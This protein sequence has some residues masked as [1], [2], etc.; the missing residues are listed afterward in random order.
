MLD[1]KSK[2]QIIALTLSPH[3]GY[4]DMNYVYLLT[5]EPILSNLIETSCNSLWGK[6]I[7]E[8]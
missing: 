7:V 4:G 3:Y 2:V 1:M 8:T 5:K 6:D